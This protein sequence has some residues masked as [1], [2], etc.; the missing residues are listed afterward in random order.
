MSYVKSLKCRECGAEF[1]VAPRAICEECFGPLE[2][3]YDYDALRRV[4]SPDAIAARPRSMWRYRELLPVDGAGILGQEVG[5][6]RSSGPTGWRGA[7][8][9]RSCTSR[10]TR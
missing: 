9:W 10:T 8:E 2:V 6:R 3:T 4:F 5:G 7:S 1:P